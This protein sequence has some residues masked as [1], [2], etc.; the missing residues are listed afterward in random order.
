MEPVSLLRQ[1]LRYWRKIYKTYIDE[2]TLGYCWTNYLLK[3]SNEWST[4]LSTLTLATMEVRS[5]ISSAGATQFNK[6]HPREKR[7]SRAMAKSTISKFTNNPDKHQVALRKL[8]QKRR[9]RIMNK[10]EEVSQIVPNNYTEWNGKIDENRRI[11]WMIDF[12]IKKRSEY[13]FHK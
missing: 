12:H 7:W 4:N 2:V 3:I 8:I 13:L 1:T 11:A 10:T 6:I 5:D 9:K